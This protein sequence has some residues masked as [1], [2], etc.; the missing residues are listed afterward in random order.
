[1]DFRLECNDAEIMG[2]IKPAILWGLCCVKS[3]FHA[4]PLFHSY[5]VIN[6]GL[7]MHTVS[8][9]LIILYNQPPI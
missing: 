9:H 2:K 4:V 1:M 7:K 3:V 8:S 5:V 6:A